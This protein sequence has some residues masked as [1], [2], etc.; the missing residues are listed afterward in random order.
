VLDHAARVLRPGGVLV[1]DTVARTPVSRL[2][3]LGAFQAIPGTRIMPRHRY[4]AERL[5][6]PAEIVAALTAAGLTSEDVCGFRPRS[7]AAL[8]RAV[9][10]RKSGR[11][12]DE[13]LPAAVE[14]VLDPGHEPPVTYLGA[15]RRPE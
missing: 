14:F 9:L 11:L 10:A 5:R 3:S 1:Y 7:I 13:D 2:I 8:V 12:R 4:R 15:A 6:P